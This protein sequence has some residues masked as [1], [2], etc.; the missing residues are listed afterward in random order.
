[1]ITLTEAAAAAV[2]RHLEKNARSG[3]ALRLRVA[4]GGCSGLRYELAIDGH[5]AESDEEFRQHGVR[6]AVDAKSAPYLVGA[7]LDYLD[8]L[9]ESG[10]K[11]TNPNATSTCGCG[12]SF[13]A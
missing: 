5:V 6:L 7:T 2:K 8:G 1:M 12:E 9:N 13:D 4:G 10:F 3:D 11:I